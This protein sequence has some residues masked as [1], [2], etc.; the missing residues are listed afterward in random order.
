MQLGDHGTWTVGH[1]VFGLV[2][3]CS[4]NFL[5]NMLYCS[6]D[7]V[8]GDMSLASKILE[9]IFKVFG[10]GFALKGPRKNFSR[11]CI[12]GHRPTSAVKNFNKVIM[13]KSTEAPK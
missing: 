4:T 5:M 7:R 9:D 3:Y 1:A 10:L 8:L 6:S 2:Y 11:A 12:I 13:N